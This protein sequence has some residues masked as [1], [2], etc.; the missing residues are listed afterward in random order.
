MGGQGHTPAALSQGKRPGT[1]STVPWVGPR[2]GIDG[3]GKSCP[4]AGF[5]PRTVPT[6]VGARFCVPVQIDPDAYPACP[7]MGT[8]V[9][10]F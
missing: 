3:C 2:V 5:D 6:L 7:T 4:P 9:L 8:G 1:H 10:G